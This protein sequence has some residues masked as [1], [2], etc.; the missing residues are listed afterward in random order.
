MILKMIPKTFSELSHN[1][2][3]SD[4]LTELIQRWL[5]LP[6]FVPFDYFLSQIGY[7]CLSCEKKFLKIFIHHYRHH[8]GIQISIHGF[9]NACNTDNQIIIPLTDYSFDEYLE[10]V[11][12]FHQK[13]FS[14]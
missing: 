14:I 8:E 10:K 2:N 3:L 5:H 13:K 12:D 6:L 4:S 1:L 9:C 11:E 7:H